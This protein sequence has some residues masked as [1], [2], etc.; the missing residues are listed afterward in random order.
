MF[1][2]TINKIVATKNNEDT[3]E[4]EILGEKKEALII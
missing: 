3:K 4:F 1:Y 2:L